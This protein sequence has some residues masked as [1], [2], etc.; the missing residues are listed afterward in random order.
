MD[1]FY[2]RRRLIGLYGSVELNYRDFINLTLNARNDWS[3]TLPKENKS[4]FYPGVNASIDLSGIFT[5]IEDVFDLAKIRVG[6]AKVGKDADP[7]LINSVFVKGEQFDGYR[8]LRYP[9]AGNINSFE[10]ETG[11]VTQD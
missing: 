10:V 1:E 7:Y 5:G 4:F 3:S 11:S 2:S 8:F 6:W 9:L